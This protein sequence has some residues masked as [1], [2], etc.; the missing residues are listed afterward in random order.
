MEFEK[1]M[2]TKCPLKFKQEHKP[3]K[4]DAHGKIE[5]SFQNATCTPENMMAGGGTTL[6]NPVALEMD[7]LA[8]REEKLW[9]NV[10]SHELF[11]AFGITHT[12][13]RKDR[14]N[15]ISVLHENMQKDAKDQFEM[16]ADCKLPDRIPYDCGS[17]MHYSDMQG[18]IDPMQKKTMVSKNEHFC[19]TDQL[20]P[21]RVFNGP[22]RNDWKVLRYTLGCQ[23]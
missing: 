23:Y 6:R 7:Y 2:G 3:G 17:I 14:D 4:G 16:C 19:P 18:S 10:F 12:H 5:I 1:T 9:G 21:L 13:R 15:Y 22:T 20:G 11:H 8:C